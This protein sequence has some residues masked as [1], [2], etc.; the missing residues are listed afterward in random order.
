MALL[1]A[2]CAAPR[3]RWF[4]AEPQGHAHNDYLHARP[5]RD[6]LAAGFHSV[7]A[8]VFLE[9][10]ELRIG[11]ERWMLRAGR[12]LERLYLE[13][14]R[15]QVQARGGSVLGDGAPFLLLVDVKQ[16]GAAVY[17]CLQTVL[18][19]YRDV[20]TRFVDGRIE[21]GAVTVVLSGDRPRALAERDGDRLMALDGRI[22]DLDGGAPAA[23]V[24]LVS[25]AWSKHFTWD[26]VGPMPD[27]ERA[28]LR[29]FAARACAQGRL[30]RFWGAPDRP[31]AWDELARDG[32]T[33]LNTDRLREF[34]A[35]AAVRRRN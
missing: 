8:D 28:R 4:D 29:A 1:L 15:L 13:P 9:E 24:P 19:A 16:D 18:A 2:A 21:P 11:H 22:A 17:L 12:T 10:G 30:L 27:A 35:W 6:A 31:E 23:L 25:D 20:L 3:P 7:E 33:L 5:L 34:A 32:V 14:L 26:A